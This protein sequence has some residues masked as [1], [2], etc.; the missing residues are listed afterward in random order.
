MDARARLPL[1]AFCCALALVC[2]QPAEAQ[3]AHASLAAMPAFIAPTQP[4][5]GARISCT[6]R[7]VRSTRARAAVVDATRVSK[8]ERA[9][10]AGGVTLRI[11]NVEAGVAGSRCD[12]ELKLD[13]DVGSTPEG[14]VILDFTDFAASGIVLGSPDGAKDAAFTVTARLLETGTD[15]PIQ[16]ARPLAV[17]R[18]TTTD[19]ERGPAGDNESDARDASG[20]LAFS[21]SGKQVFRVVLDNRPQ[22]DTE[23]K[24]DADGP[25]DDTRG[26]TAETSSVTDDET[27]RL[28]DDAK[29]E[30]G[31]VGGTDRDLGAQSDT[32]AS[33][34]AQDDGIATGEDPHVVDAAA[35]DGARDCCRA[36]V[37]LDTP[38]ALS[39]DD[40]PVTSASSRKP[41]AIA[42][43][44]QYQLS[45]LPSGEVVAPTF[46]RLLGSFRGWMDILDVDIKNRATDAKVRLFFRNDDGSL[47]EWYDGD[48]YL[49]GWRRMLVNEDFDFTVTLEGFSR[50]TDGDLIDSTIETAQPLFDLEFGFT[51]V[52]PS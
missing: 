41:A 28:D 48:T 19:G 37:A 4:S 6:G 1:A 18:L 15:I 45:Y 20:S 31:T 52:I 46:L 17:E 49:A 16:T 40:I 2:P 26:E 11:P 29:P 21:W 38:Q 27:A 36:L 35:L 22:D 24:D 34:Q 25:A 30:E 39:A 9:S 10:G 51:P 8:S 13:A 32:E 7:L 14:T 43:P 5:H 42:F 23:R 33:S 50:E 47:E 12:L 44:K 3:E